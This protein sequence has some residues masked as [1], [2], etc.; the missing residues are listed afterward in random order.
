MRPR[1]LI[2]RD[3][4]MSMR[5]GVVLRGDVWRPEVEEPVAAILLR[6]PYDRRGTNSDVLR[7][8]ECVEAGFACV[9]QDTRGRFGSDGEWEI[10]M[11]EQEALDSHDTVE[12][13]AAQDWCDGAVGMAGA[14]YLGIVQWV[15]A[16]ERPPHLK[17]FAPAMTTSGELD[18]LDTGGAVRLTQVVCW[19]AYMALDWVSR[20]IAAGRPVEM[21]KVAQLMAV[22]GEPRQTLEQLPLESIDAFELEGFPLTLG[23]MLREGM[24]AVTSFRYPEIE[25]PTLSLVGWFDFLSTGAIESFM[26]IRA[27]GGGG[28]ESR[29]AHRLIVGPWGHAGT[30]PGSQGEVNFGI[31][32]GPFAGVSKKHLAFF[33]R[34]LR[35]TAEELPVVEYFLMGAEEWRTAA[36][37]PPPE[38][39]PQEWYLS[40]GGTANTGG[41]DGLLA[42]VLPGTSAPADRYTYDPADPVRTHGG[43]TIPMGELVAGPFDQA[44]TEERADVLCYTTEVLPEALDIA[45]PVF[46]RLFAATSGRDTDWVGRLVDVGPD[47][48][49]IAFAEGILRARFRN[50][51]V[52]ELVEPGELV[53]Y[54]VPLGHTAWRVRAGHR[55]RLQVTSSN[56]P[57]FD[58]NMNTGAE[59]G[60]DA[61]GVRAEQ[62]VFHTPEHRSALELTTLPPQ[63]S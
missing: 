13:V 24:D 10:L 28:E 55:L 51:P 6:S 2:E 29:A 4:E 5:D 60:S 18:R 37:W 22:V 14:S 61:A 16:A 41:G 38:S 40:S 17:A 63:S 44:R 25:A 56:F 33:D 19:L 7:P 1:A 43:R 11:W 45:G 49:A 20:E 31:G 26:R 34:H 12:W 58:R 48:R 54:R 32:D 27:E 42:R 46:L 47:D 30:L 15:G 57:A 39:R 59:I 52:E 9:V 53:S 23:E 36:A 21:S 62:T 3:V 8:F 35:G 50:G